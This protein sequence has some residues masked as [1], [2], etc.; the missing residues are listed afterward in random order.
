MKKS[1]SIIF[2]FMLFLGLQVESQAQ[3][4]ATI[5]S[6]V[7]VSCNGDATGSATATATGGTAPYTFLWD[8]NAG[9]QTTA[10]ATGLVASIYS[11]TVTDANGLTA[12][13]SVTINE[14]TSAVAVTAAV[15]SNYNGQDISCQGAVD[16][17]IT[18]AAT[19]GIAP[20]TYSID[21][22]VTMQTSNVFSFLG[23]GTYQLMVMDVNACTDVLSITLTEPVALSTSFTNANLCSAPGVQ[24]GTITAV[25]S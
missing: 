9:N 14:P 22:G 18:A 17:Q 25:V 16:G 15:T 5:A 11:V 20:Y 19:G 24:D 1:N 3:V 4:T 6:S 7:D 2:L 10:T 12:T 21:G 13:T 23:A 8:A